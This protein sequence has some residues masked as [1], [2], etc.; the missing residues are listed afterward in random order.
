MAMGRLQVAFIEARLGD[1][2]K[3]NT[4]AVQRMLY[5]ARTGVRLGA[6]AL[7]DGEEAWALFLAWKEL[8][9]LLAY[10]PEDEASS[11]C[12]AGPAPGL[13]LEYPIARR[14]TGRGGQRAY[15][16]HCFNA[17][18]QSNY[19]FY[20]EEDVTL[21]VAN[22][23]RLGVVLGAVCDD[24]VESL[25]AILKQAYNDH[26]ACGRGRVPGATALQREGEVVLPARQWWFLKFDLPLQYHGGPHTAPCT[27]AK[28]MATQSP[29]PSFFS[30]RS[31]AL[32]SPPHG[33]RNVEV[34]LG[35]HVESPRR[36]PGILVVLV[37]A[38]WAFWIN[39]CRLIL[40]PATFTM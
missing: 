3:N 11:V 31:L 25:N 37:V 30:S 39:F 2:P 40:T 27:M 4:G 20:L 24:V 28:H 1:L 12:H 13:V 10:A 34:P 6:S 7:P 9:P 36:P 35:G 15:R 38:F 19:L 33:P 29:P 14:P 21:G 16:L 22:A 5:R 8:G 26:T 23:A 17:A 32:V 18:C